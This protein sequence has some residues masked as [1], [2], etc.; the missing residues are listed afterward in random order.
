MK[1]KKTIKREKDTDSDVEI[2]HPNTT[3][4]SQPHKNQRTK[5]KKELTLT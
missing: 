4:A 3:R 5:K 2:C 1:T